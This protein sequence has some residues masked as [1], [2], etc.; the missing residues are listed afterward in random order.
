MTSNEK[1][2]TAKFYECYSH[3]FGKDVSASLIEFFS[4]NSDS[5]INRINEKN[6]FKYCCNCLKENFVSK[7]STIVS[8]SR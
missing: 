1:Q 6:I 8:D 7:N 5:T 3:Y 2:I 4:K